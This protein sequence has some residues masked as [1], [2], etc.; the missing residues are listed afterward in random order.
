[1][2][3]ILVDQM[4]SSNCYFYE[5]SSVGVFIHIGLLILTVEV[6][7]YLIFDKY[8]HVQLE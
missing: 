2:A 8:L 1:M 5:L 6:P 3:S 7:I 4:V